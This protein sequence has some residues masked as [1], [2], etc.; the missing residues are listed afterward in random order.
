M[1]ILFAL[2]IAFLIFSSATKGSDLPQFR[3]VTI[4]NKVKIGYGVAI[5]DMNADKKK[6][7]IFIKMLQWDKW[8]CNTH[9]CLCALVQID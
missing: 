1:K 9:M 4:D 3:H 7:I 5:A 8:D 2:L 6:D